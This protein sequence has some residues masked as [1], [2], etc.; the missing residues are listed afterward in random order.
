MKMNATYLFRP[1]AQR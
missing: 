1:H